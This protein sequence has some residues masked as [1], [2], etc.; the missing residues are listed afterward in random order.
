MRKGTDKM[1]GVSSVEWLG[2][3]KLSVSTSTFSTLW[4]VDLNRPEPL[5][6]FPFCEF[7]GLP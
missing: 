1:Y 2:G 6:R 3:A 5:L 7:L 4:L